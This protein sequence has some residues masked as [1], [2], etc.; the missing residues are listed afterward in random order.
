MYL[1]FGLTP[2]LYFLGHA[3]LNGY[4]LS[5]LMA[6]VTHAYLNLSEGIAP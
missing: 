4:L 2:H 5:Q 1:P 3:F 6:S